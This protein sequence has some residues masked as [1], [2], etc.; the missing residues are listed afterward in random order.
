MDQRYKWPWDHGSQLLSQHTVSR[1][2]SNSAWSVTQCYW[3]ENAVVTQPLPCH[4]HSG[5]S[6]NWNKPPLPPLPKH[7][8]WNLNDHNETTA[9]QLVK[10]KT[11]IPTSPLVLNQ[12]I[13]VK[14][15]SSF[16]WNITIHHSVFVTQQFET[17]Q[18]IHLRWSDMQ[19]SIQKERNKG[20][21]F[22]FSVLISPTRC[23][24][25]LLSSHAMRSSK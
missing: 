20:C 21:P 12:M 19:W 18:W 4:L 11:I 16:F 1:H 6:F 24:P 3:Y 9:G 8:W 10:W 5:Y 2:E 22:L 23:V 14:M 25:A 15:E 7:Q 13:C 17:I